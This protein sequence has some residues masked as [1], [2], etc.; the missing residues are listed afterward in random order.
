MAA[1]PPGGGSGVGQGPGSEYAAYLARVR[2]RI[3]EGLRYPP[4]ARRRG[5]TGT[6]QLEIA[7][8]ADGAIS[9]VAV[10]TSSS[11]EILDRAAADAARSAPRVPFPANVRPRP[12]TVRLPVVFELQ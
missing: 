10:A 1:L 3:Q 7:I 12:L 11:H 4:A 6:V 8:A 9:S 2:Q 5:V